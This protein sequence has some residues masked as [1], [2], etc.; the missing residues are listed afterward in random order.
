MIQYSKKAYSLSGKIFLKPLVAYC[1]HVSS[2]SAMA[3]N[4]MSSIE[5]LL[6]DF[7]SGPLDRYRHQSSFCWKKMK[8]LLD[9]ESIIRFKMDIWHRLERDPI[10]QDGVLT[11]SLAEQRR[12]ATERLYRIKKWNLV[13]LEV[14][15]SDVRL[16][17]AH[18]ETLIQCCPSATIKWSLA[19]GM[20]QSVILGL[21]TEQHFHFFEE[22]SKPDTEIAGCFAL[23][24]IAHGTNVKGMRTTATYIPATQ[25]FELHTPDFEAAKCW[26][27]CLGQTC[28]HAIVYARLITADGVDHGL[29]AF[30]TPIRSTKSLLPLPGVIVGDM[31]EKIGLNGVDNGFVMFNKFRIPRESLL[32][33]TGDV[34]PDGTYT[35]PYKDSNKRFGASL[36][37]LSSGRVSITNMC[38]NYILKAIVIAIRYSAV[39]KQ[40]A[41]SEVSEE[42]LPI[43]EY[44][45]QQWRLFPYLAA[46]YALKIFGSYFCQKFGEF[47]MKTFTGQSKD[48]MIAVGP[49]I[50]ALSSASKPIAGWI[51]RDGIQEC[52]EACGGHGYL[53]VSG[54]GDLRNDN[55]PNCTYEGDNNVLMQQTSNW[56]LSLYKSNNG[57]RS[58][59]ST[60]FDS[61]SFLSNMKEILNSK[62]SSSDITSPESL[63]A[64]YQWLICYLLK[65]TDNRLDS[66]LRCGKDSF[67]AKNDSQVYY[68]HTLSKAYIEHYI[69]KIFLQ[70][71]NDNAN[72]QNLKSVLTTLARLYGSWSLEKHLATLYQG[73]FLKNG[74]VATSL[75]NGIINLC[76][77]LKTNAVS[78]V[79]AIAPPDFVLNSALGMSDG[80][81][82]KNLQAALYQNPDVFVRPSWWDQIIHS[83][84]RAKL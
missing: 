33:K 17:Y 8:L 50:H 22:C 58:L 82:Y 31:G 30:V 19:F 48:D 84:S 42:E 63:I 74:E 47:Q 59:F 35:S 78:L 32:N 65:S 18:H 66:N 25:E 38:T 62:F 67:T 68:A 23:T 70:F 79:D 13:P 80:Q 53:K 3:S 51:A 57:D 24:E 41:P 81:V 71:I 37:M 40:F 69:L 14:I 76:A 29:H 49:E 1:N 39:R 9:D 5:E 83:S 56:L 45:L 28:T 75:R 7:P 21:G 16:M 61:V 72:E 10:F 64:A 52:R 73:G 46:T 43:I 54:I 27:G 20:F 34:L 11:P 6:K 55:D 2:K 44:Q 36:G 12:L 26:V 15:I 77:E 60:P 4:K